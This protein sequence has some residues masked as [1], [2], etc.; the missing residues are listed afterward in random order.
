MRLAWFALAA[1]LVPQTA[2]ADDAPQPPPAPPPTDAPP[3]EAPTEAPPGPPPAPAPA[4]EDPDVRPFRPAPMRKDIVITVDGDRTR[5][6]KLM[7]AGIAAGG[8]LLAGIGLYYNLDSRDAATAVSPKHA[9][10]SPWSADDQANYDRAHSSGVKAGVFYGLGGAVLIGAAVAYM[11]TAPKSE[12]T[13]IHPHYSKVQPII[14]PSPT[15]ALVGG[16]WRF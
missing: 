1:A 5:D 6:N 16:A 7:I 10:N 8:V 14:A 2:V 11:V 15:G 12:T 4:P 13:T 9:I 3:P